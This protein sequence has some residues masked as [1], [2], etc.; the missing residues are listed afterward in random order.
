MLKTRKEQDNFI[1]NLSAYIPDLI[2]SADNDNV[3]EYCEKMTHFILSSLK[4]SK[5]K[6]TRRI[7]S[8]EA[9]KLMKERNALQ[10]KP[11]LT[12]SEKENLKNLY[13]IT[14]KVIKK[15]YDTYRIT[16]IKRHLEKSRSAKK[17]YKELNTSKKWIPSLQPGSTKFRTRVR[18]WE[19]AEGVASSWLCAASS[20]ASSSS[21]SSMSRTSMRPTSLE[22]FDSVTV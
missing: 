4:G 10:N 15:C 20:L 8:E 22:R 17:A 5:T 14:N 9:L 12:K 1:K 21:T 3:N 11:K 19:R 13:K 6:Q 7:L 16:S 2:A 18:C